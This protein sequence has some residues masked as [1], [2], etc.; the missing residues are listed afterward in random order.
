MSQI[1]AVLS[2]LG[3][4][5]IPVQM[6]HFLK[7]LAESSRKDMMLVN[8]VMKKTLEVGREIDCGRRTIRQTFDEFIAGPLDM[9]YEQFLDS[10]YTLLGEEYPQVRR[11]YERLTVPLYILSNINDVHA[12]Y[13]HGRWFDKLSIACWMSN[14]IGMAKPSREVFKFVLAEIKC[15][16]EELLFFDDIQE[17]T[18]GAAALG[19][20]AILVKDPD[21][22]VKTLQANNLLKN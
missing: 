22:V 16:P 10:W 20:N 12:E 21:D 2:D 15:R 11:A 7:N 6:G 17:N 1:K 18:D 9:N 5:V 13:L 14:E 3:N 4:V 19:I 8:D